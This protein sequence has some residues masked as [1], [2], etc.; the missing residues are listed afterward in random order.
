MNKVM[1]LCDSCIRMLFGPAEVDAKL[2]AAHE[3]STTEECTC[4]NAS[5]SLVHLVADE[6]YNV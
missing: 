4:C 1:W 5:G 2:G 6:E 3:T